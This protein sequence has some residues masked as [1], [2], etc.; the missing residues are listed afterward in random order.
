[1]REG[2]GA[3]EPASVTGRGGRGGSVCGPGGCGAQVGR[4]EAW[5]LL[6]W[7]STAQGPPAPTDTAWRDVQTDPLGRVSS[8]L[9]PFAALGP[10]Q[11]HPGQTGGQSSRGTSLRG[12][13]HAQ[14][15]LGPAPRPQ[16]PLVSCHCPAL[17]GRGAED[18][19]GDATSPSACWVPGVT[20]GGRLSPWPSLSLVSQ[21]RPGPCWWSPGSLHGG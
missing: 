3:W 9:R 5:S 12:R 2:V 4:W 7:G 13:G 8:C 16:P 10:G 19:L 18:R 6:G 17:L 11:C 20:L 14:Q 15:G 1:M 21:D